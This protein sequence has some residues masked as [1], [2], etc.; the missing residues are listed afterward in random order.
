MIVEISLEKC[1]H[2]KHLSKYNYNFY[3]M[4]IRVDG[5]DVILVDF[6]EEFNTY[7]YH[8]IYPSGVRKPYACELNGYECSDKIALDSELAWD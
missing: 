6:D 8:L 3:Q 5:T 1:D 2:L 7:Q 4:P